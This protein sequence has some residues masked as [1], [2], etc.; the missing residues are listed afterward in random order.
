[1][2][3]YIHIYIISDEIKR[4]YRMPPQTQTKTQETHASM[5]A[6]AYYVL[7][8]ALLLLGHCPAHVGVDRIWKGVGEGEEEITSLLHRTKTPPLSPLVLRHAASSPQSRLFPSLL[9]TQTR[10]SISFALGIPSEAMA[11]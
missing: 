8:L 11:W 10:L 6:H 7:C 3:N 5:H 2:L 4:E 9:S 1:M